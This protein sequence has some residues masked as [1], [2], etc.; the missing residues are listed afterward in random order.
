[1]KRTIIIAVLLA[2]TAYAILVPGLAISEDESAVLLAKTLYTLARDQS[3]EVMLALGG[4]VMNRVANPWFPDTVAE[5]IE[6]PHQFAHGTKYDA[7]SLRIA[8]A[9]LSGR[10][11]LRRNV[12]YYH[13]LDAS[14]VWDMSGAHEI[15][16]NYGF[17]IKPAA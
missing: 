7:R 15:L 6:Q 2:L 11:P 10:Y 13:A 1:M 12:V 14:Q 9:A 16:G 8:N 3:D 17:F 5:V 4:V